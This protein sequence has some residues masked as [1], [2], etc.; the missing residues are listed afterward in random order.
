MISRRPGSS[1]KD[2]P[3]HRFTERPQC[4]AL[5]D[6]IRTIGAPKEYAQLFGRTPEL[7]A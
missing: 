6:F 1:G 3:S 4:H 5:F 7:R 2:P